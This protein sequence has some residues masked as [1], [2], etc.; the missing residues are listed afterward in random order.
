MRSST[1]RLAGGPPITSHLFEGGEVYLASVANGRKWTLSCLAGSSS[2]LLRDAKKYLRQPVIDSDMRTG[3]EW[4]L[5]GVPE[6]LDV[7]AHDP[8]H[9]L[10]SKVAE[11]H[12]SR[13]TGRRTAGRTHRIYRDLKEDTW[14]EDHRNFVKTEVQMPDGKLAS[15]QYSVDDEKAPGQPAKGQADDV[16]PAGIAARPPR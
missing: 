15:F 12:I 16:R 13:A 9:R 8:A 10:A 7:P 5:F 4:K 11:G 2:A 3:L 1:S 6:R 14:I